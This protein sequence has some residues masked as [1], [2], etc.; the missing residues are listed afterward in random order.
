[1]P[2]LYKLCKVVFEENQKK[3]RAPKSG[4]SHSILNEIENYKEHKDQKNT[5]SG[6]VFYLN[7]FGHEIYL[8][9][10][11]RSC[12]KTGLLQINIGHNS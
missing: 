1:M 12:S 4:I 10:V 2:N 9:E 11:V 3:L 5:R 6:L 8:S 7:Q